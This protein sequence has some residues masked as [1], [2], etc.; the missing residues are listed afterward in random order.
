MFSDKIRTINYKTQLSNPTK[1]IV[2]CDGDSCACRCRASYIHASNRWEI[3]NFCEP[4]TCSNPSISQDHGKLL[5]FLIGKS[6]HNLIENDS[7]TS[8]LALIAY[9]KSTKGY[10]TTYREAW[11]E[12]QKVIGN[13]YGNWERLYH[14][15]LRLLQ[16]MQKF[17]P[18]IVVEKETLPMP[19]QGGQAV[20][21]F[22][23]FHRHFWS[24]RPYIDEFQYCKL[25]VQVDETWLYGKYK[26][27]LL[28]EVAQDGNNK[29]LPIAFAVFKSESTGAWLFFLQN[30][31]GMLSHNMVCVWF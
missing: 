26:G 17:L 24:F 28:V 20:E 19:P 15:L 13:I 14:D 6:I 18:L 5:Y 16:A 29:I 1:L 21:G 2:H 30:L 10:T 11:L 27:T 7:S 9:I 4:H 3:R 23:M 8:V 25:I 12:K 22:I 31:K